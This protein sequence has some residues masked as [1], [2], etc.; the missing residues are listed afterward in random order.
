MNCFP[1]SLAMT[2][3]SVSF[4]TGAFSFSIR[5]NLKS[6]L[7]ASSLVGLPGLTARNKHGIKPNVL[8]SECTYYVASSV[9]LMY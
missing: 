1:V 9:V 2:S 8:E 3:R 4:L 6:L 5:T 7:E